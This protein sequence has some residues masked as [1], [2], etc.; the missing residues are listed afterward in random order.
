MEEDIKEIKKILKDFIT[1]YTLKSLKI[2]ADIEYHTKLNTEDPR[3]WKTEYYSTVSN[4]DL[5]LKQ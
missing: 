4:I 1:T 5:E 3:R 2:K